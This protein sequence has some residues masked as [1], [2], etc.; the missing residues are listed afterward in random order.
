[1]RPVEATSPTTL[2]F[3]G[4]TLNA[5]VAEDGQTYIPLRELCACLNLSRAGELRRVKAAEA[6]AEGLRTLAVQSPAGRAR[7]T[8]CLR[9]DL[10]PGW[11]LG[12]RLDQ[13]TD[14]TLRQKLETYQ[15]E[16]C[17]VAWQVFGPEPTPRAIE[18]T[19][20]TFANRLEA[21]SQ[22]LEAF[23]HFLASLP[24]SAPESAGPTPP[25]DV[26]L[27]AKITWYPTC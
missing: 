5:A 22:R 27:G 3:Y 19:L 15:R 17:Q 8:P 6:L 18:E 1:M 10:I 4:A 20:A 25:A 24:E 2:E 12:A 16:L 21:T 26:N 9:V 7:Q 23:A 13:I 14:P 11:L